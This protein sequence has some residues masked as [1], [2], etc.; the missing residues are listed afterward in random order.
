MKAEQ[1]IVDKKLSKEAISD[2]GS[3]YFREVTFRLAV[4]DKLT[5][6]PHVSVQ[7]SKVLTFRA[8]FHFLFMYLITFDSKAFIVARSHL[9]TNNFKSN[10]LYA[11]F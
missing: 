1:N 9:N 5:N 3:D 11:L 10:F 2:I 4:G 6:L 8:S 7:V